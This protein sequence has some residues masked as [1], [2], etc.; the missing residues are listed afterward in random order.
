MKK[1]L[2]L[3]L[4]LAMVVSCVAVMQMTTFA[5]SEDTILN[6]DFEDTNAA[7]YNHDGI[8]N[9][10]KVTVTHEKAD[11]NS[12]MQFVTTKGWEAPYWSLGSKVKAFADANPGK[13]ICFIGSADVKGAGTVRLLFRNAGTTDGNLALGT[14]VTVKN[15]KWTK[16]GGFALLDAETVAT[17]AANANSYRLMFDN[18]GTNNG[19]GTFQIDNMVI[20]LKAVDKIAGFEYTVTDNNNSQTGPVICNTAFNHDLSFLKDKAKDGK[21]TLNYTIYNQSDIDMKFQAFLQVNWAFITNDGKRAWPTVSVKAKQSATVSFVFDIDADGKV[22]KEDGSKVDLTKASLRFDFFDAEGNA[23]VAEGTKFTIIPEDEVLVDWMAK[24]SGIAV[25]GSPVGEAPVLPTP[26]AGEGE[27]TPTPTPKRATGMKLTFNEDVEFGGQDTQFLNT[28]SG[29][30][31]AADVKNGEITKSFQI[32]NNGTETISI[33]LRLQA[34]V[35]N[36][37]GDGTWHGNPNTNDR[38]EIEPGKVGTVSITVPVENGKVTILDQEVP[39]EKLFARFD[40]TGEGG[41]LSLAKGASFTIFCDEEVAQGLV[42][43]WMS[44]SD[45][46]SRELSYEVIGSNAS[47][48]G[49]ILPVAFV[50]M[51]VVASAALIVVSR[52]RREEI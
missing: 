23:G 19:G 35:K 28:A 1:L 36:E 40:I 34:L 5:A 33:V 48:T 15:D 18:L 9:N 51:A 41:E 8:M 11:G 25:Q 10:G 14:T 6:V 12:Y 44:N 52:K 26:G 13:K 31:S 38:V 24:L 27:A 7:G 37:N 21:V 2:S 16:I 32:K 42:N 49:D 22:T 20:T 3:M 29:I 30:V 50:A 4:V 45:K 17:A 39:V 46:I 47:G 43:S